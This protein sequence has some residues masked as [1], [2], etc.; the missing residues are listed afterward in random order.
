MSRPRKS[1]IK[2]DFCVE[3]ADKLKKDVRN[4]RRR[5]AYHNTVVDRRL[6]LMAE[7]VD[8]LET[9]IVA[10]NAVVSSG[11]KSKRALESL[12]DAIEARANRP[13]DT[14]EV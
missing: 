12:C 4:W 14:T 7:H 13:T 8:E 6:M 9:L 5:V 10:I 1:L 3:G 2:P 11:R